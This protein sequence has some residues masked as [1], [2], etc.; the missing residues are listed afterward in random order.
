MSPGTVLVYETSIHILRFSE[1]LACLCRCLEESSLPWIN[2]STQTVQTA[3][4]WYATCAV[5]SMSIHAYWTV[6]T[7]SVPAACAVE[8][9]TAVSHAPS[10]G[11]NLFMRLQTKNPNALILRNTTALLNA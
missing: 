1:E 7:L 6:T 11:K 3:T 9:W 2:F 5:S 4:P 10:V 8:Q